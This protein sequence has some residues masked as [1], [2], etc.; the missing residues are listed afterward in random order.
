MHSLRTF[1]FRLRHGPS[2]HLM[3]REANTRTHPA[4]R[5]V[6]LVLTVCLASCALLGGGSQTDANS[7]ARKK[8]SSATKGVVKDD[9]IVPG[10]RIGPVAVGMSVSQLYD[11]MG[12]PTQSE[13]GRGTERCVFE[14]LE[15]VMD[16]ADQSVISVATQSADYATADDIKVGLADLG[17]RAK[18]AKLSGRLLI[19]EEGDT[20]TYFTAGMMILVSG[21]HVKSIAVRSVSSVPNG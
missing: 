10:K 6:P 7:V 15:V 19:K 4:L 16:D 2:I 11:V 21:G 17:V 13:K 5:A 14:D 12:A 20:I 1:A 9:L 18:L 3:R 8:P